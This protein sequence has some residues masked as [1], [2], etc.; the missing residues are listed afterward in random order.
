MSSN[1]NYSIA[2]VGLTLILGGCRISSP[3]VWQSVD[4]NLAIELLAENSRNLLKAE[5]LA[6]I[7]SGIEAIELKP[8][9]AVAVNIY[10][11]NTEQLCGIG[12]CLH[13]IYLDFPRKLLFRILLSKQAKIETEDNCLSFS[14]PTKRDNIKLKY[15]YQRSEYVQQAITHTSHN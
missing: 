5:N 12:G 13:S 8:A 6:Q 1:S 4:R 2:I 10:R 14:Q 11:F 9:R 7:Q 3:P 15:C